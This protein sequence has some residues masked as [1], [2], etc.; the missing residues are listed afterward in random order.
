MK[1]ELLLTSLVMLNPVA[2]AT[3]E[4]IRSAVTRNASMNQEIA[5]MIVRS[6]VV[7]GQI[8]YYDFETDTYHQQVMEDYYVQIEFEILDES[9]SQFILPITVIGRPDLAMEYKASAYVV[10]ASDDK[11][12]TQL[13]EQMFVRRLD[14]N[15]FKLYECDSTATCEE[16]NYNTKMHI[17]TDRRTGKKF[18]KINNT[19][20]LWWDTARF[21]RFDFVN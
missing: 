8:S 1:K 3:A 6:K 20:N 9:N 14:E 7:R 12:L 2:Q 21:R 11:K 10:R 13:G 15:S 16:E 5:D 17:L 19:N 4:E 18:L